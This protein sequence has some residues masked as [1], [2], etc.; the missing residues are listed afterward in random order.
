MSGRRKPKG[1]GR[2]AKSLE[3]RLFIELI[4]KGVSIGAAC[5]ELAMAR[6]NAHP[7]MYGAAKL[8]SSALGDLYKPEQIQIRD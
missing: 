6:S 4:A 1:P 8:C 7:N 3:C 5:G 2:H